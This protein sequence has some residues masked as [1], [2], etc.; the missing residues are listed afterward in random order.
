MD[1]SHQA[2]FLPNQFSVSTKTLVRHLIDEAEIPGYGLIY[3]ESVL[4]PHYGDRRSLVEPD[5]RRGWT[6]Q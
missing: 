4:R 1:H 6:A 2:C 5:L 3:R